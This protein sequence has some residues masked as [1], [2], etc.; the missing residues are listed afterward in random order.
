MVL[1]APEH[2]RSRRRARVH[3]PPEAR[4][5]GG[6]VAIYHAGAPGALGVGTD[7]LGPGAASVAAH[8][9]GCVGGGGARLEGQRVQVGGGTG[10]VVPVVRIRVRVRV[11]VRVGGGAGE[12]VPVIRGRVVR[13]RA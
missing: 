2:H 8:C 12:V 5:R 7:E 1:G 10:E 9:E 4:V 13:V 11:R 3:L 6:H